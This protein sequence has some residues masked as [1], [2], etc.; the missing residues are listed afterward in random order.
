MSRKAN[1][2][3]P[4]NEYA[5]HTNEQRHYRKR[6]EQRDVLMG[7]AAAGTWLAKQPSL[8]GNAYAESLADDFPDITSSGH[9]KDLSED[10]KELKRLR[11]ARLKR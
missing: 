8:V 11:I 9:H 2:R 3:H 7:M 6:H 4:V 10:L 5:G 1:N